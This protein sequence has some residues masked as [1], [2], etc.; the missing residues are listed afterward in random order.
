[1]HEIESN[2][3]EQLVILGAGYDSRALRFNQLLRHHGIAVFEVDLPATQFWKKSLLKSNGI[4]VPEYLTFV[5]V[6]FGEDD[7]REIMQKHG[8]DPTKQTVFIF[9][10]VSMYISSKEFSA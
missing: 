3:A 10:G 4:A 8:Y 2:G 9:E 5:G 1:M 6:E 7:T